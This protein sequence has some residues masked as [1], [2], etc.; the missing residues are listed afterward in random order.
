M[1]FSVLI[2]L[3]MTA[4]TTYVLLI[5]KQAEWVLDAFDEAVLLNLDIMAQAGAPDKKDF[6][7]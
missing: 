5:L 4:Y 6:F 1:F 3:I 7:A 2:T